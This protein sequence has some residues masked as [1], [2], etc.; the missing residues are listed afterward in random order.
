MECCGGSSCFKE[1][2]NE[3]IDLFITKGDKTKH[4]LGGIILSALFFLLACAKVVYGAY[5]A[6]TTDCKDELFVAI[7]LTIQGCLEAIFWPFLVERIYHEKLQKTIRRSCIYIYLM[8]D[9]LFTLVWLSLGTYWTI[10]RFSEMKE[11]CVMA[12]EDWTS[13]FITFG[14]VVTAFHWLA[15]AVFML[16]MCF[17]CWEKYRRG[18]A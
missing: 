17:R 7:Y 5:K 6:G 12:R 15:M 9:F 2:K 8:L 1:W 18:D 11:T 10:G 4:K 14:V 3:C 13:H 16:Y